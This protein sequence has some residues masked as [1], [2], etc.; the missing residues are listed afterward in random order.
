MG[1]ISGLNRIAIALLIS[2]VAPAGFS[3][4][5]IGH[6][7]DDCDE[8]LSNF[9]TLD[10]SVERPLTKIFRDHAFELVS[11]DSKEVSELKLSHF[12]TLLRNEILTEALPSKQLYNWILTEKKM[13]DQVRDGS[14]PADNTVKILRHT[15]QALVVTAVASDLIP[16]VEDIETE[17]KMVFASLVISQRAPPAKWKVNLKTITDSSSRDFIRHSPLTQY[18]LFHFLQKGPYLGRV[19]VLYRELTTL[20]IRAAQE[21]QA[22][23]RPVDPRVQPFVD[24][25][26]GRHADLAALRKPWWR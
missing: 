15:L 9:A 23:K 18:R 19:E 7:G 1:A 21:I 14:L 10:T 2:V 8:L 16:I 5:P 13:G 17:Y 25:V 11:P 24:K 20:Q 12:Y 6:F 26:L 22:Q 3:A 4:S